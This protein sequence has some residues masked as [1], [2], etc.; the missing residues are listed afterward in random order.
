MFNQKYT[1][2]VAPL[3]LLFTLVSMSFTVAYLKNS[4]SQSAMEKYR[5]AEW[6]ALYSAEAGLNDV[7][8]IVLPRITSDTLLI[9]NGFNYGK[10]ENEQP[11]GLYKD[12][13]CSTRLQLNSTR[14]EYVAYAT[15]V[16]EY[17][18][19][20]GTDVSIE[21]RVY[22]TMVPQGF[23]EFMYFTDVEAPIG[24]GNTGVVNF[25]AGDQLEGKVHT[26]GDM[27]FSNYGCPEFT[28]EVNITFE[29]V[30]NGGGI[31]S[32]GACSDDIFEDDDGNTI[33]DTVSTIIFPPDNSAENARQHA[34]RTFS[35]DDKL[36][37]TGKKDTM[38]MTEINFV[39][40]G[41]WV[42]Q[43]WYNI[44]PVGSPPAEYDFLYD[45]T[46]SD[47]T[48]DPGTLHLFPNNFDGATNTYNGNFLVMSGTDLSGDNVMDEIVNLVEDGDIIRIENADGSKFMSFTATAAA[49]LGTDRVRVSFVPG[50]LIYS[51]PAGEGFNHLEI[52][53]FINTSATTGLSDNVE[54]NTYHYYHD[55]LDNGTSF[56]E[57]GR[58]QH[59]D[60]DY[61]T[62]GGT[63]CDIFSCPE[64]IYDSEYVYM[65]RSFFAKGNSPQVLYVK[66]GQLLVRGIVD[67]MYT[68]VTDDYSEYRRHDDN[69]IID[70]VW[71]NIWLI[72]DLV[73]SDSY[74]SGMVIHPTDGGTEHVLGLIAG[75]SVIIANT[76]PNGA[77]GQQY[78]SNIKI[79]AALLAMNGGFLSHYW[80][81]SLVGYHDWNDGLAYGVIADGRGGHRNH[82]RSDEQSGIYTGDDDH[83]G[84]VHLWGSIVQFKRGYMNRNFPGPYNVSPGAGYTKDYHYDWNLQLRPPPYFPDLQSNDNSVILKMASYGEAKSHE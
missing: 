24:P 73:F 34:T 48:C 1:G 64:I 75:G 74:G 39:E 6:R 79:N 58:I 7:G 47:L 50:S 61:W 29:A 76:R 68:I 60:F 59:F 69:D 83:R 11:I 13:A 25:G 54:W 15:G 2:S 3:A 62:A 23:E 32:W 31:G 43:W 81:N 65:N 84:I 44:P 4:F 18:T 36:F 66:G 38:I 12:I 26:N 63:S 67:G 5:Y 49:T 28:G 16:A 45:S 33:L 27:M 53:T 82:Y 77:R 46:S 22:T 80:Q 19:P 30:E 57:A 20:S 21:R 10:D 8:I 78:G 14:K 9:P 55:H 51:G 17:T 40:G 72:D 41:Y 56:C 52:A 70:R 35:A 71:G 42:A 37:R